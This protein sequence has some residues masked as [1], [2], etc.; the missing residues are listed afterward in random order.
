MQVARLLVL[1]KNGHLENQRDLDLVE[2]RLSLRCNYKPLQLIVI[3]SLV[4]KCIL[5]I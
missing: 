1:F 3:A 2:T 5:S 4:R